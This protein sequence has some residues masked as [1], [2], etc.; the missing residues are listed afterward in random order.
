MSKSRKYD[1]DERPRQAEPEAHKFRREIQRDI[2]ELSRVSLD[3]IDE[4]WDHYED[5]P[6][7][8]KIRK[9]PLRRQP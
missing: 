4:E 6:I 5:I 9:S 3:E 1:Y 7:F 2:G 8:E